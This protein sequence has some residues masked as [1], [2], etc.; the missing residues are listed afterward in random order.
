V[1][2]RYVAKYRKGFSVIAAGSGRVNCANSSEREAED[3][4]KQAFHNLGGAKV[5]VQRCDSRRG[6]AMAPGKDPNPSQDY[7]PLAELN[8]VIHDLLVK[9]ND[10]RPLQRLGITRRQL[11]K[12]ID[13]PHLKPLPVESSVFAEWRTRRIGIDYHVSFERNYHSVLYC[14][15]KERW[16]AT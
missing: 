4:S 13:C 2:D 12:D 11:L 5:R 8:A 15:A 9:L 6:D 10:E 16:G 14:F 3:T 7:V 1:P